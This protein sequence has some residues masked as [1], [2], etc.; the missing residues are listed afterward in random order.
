MI[1]F[2]ERTESQGM[3]TACKSCFSHE[4][5]RAAFSSLVQLGHCCPLTTP[6]DTTW[7]QGL[8]PLFPR[9]SLTHWHTRARVPA[10]LGVS[11]QIC[12]FKAAAC[13]WVPPPCLLSPRLHCRVVMLEE[14]TISQAPQAWICCAGADVCL[15]S[16]ESLLPT[17]RFC[18]VP[19]AGSHR[20]CTLG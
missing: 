9:P 1:P 7:G 16:Q 13:T 15:A 10:P 8:R 6:A 4:L 2:L 12:H 5:V 14:P 18:W 11:I 20:R 17:V 3:W 19:S